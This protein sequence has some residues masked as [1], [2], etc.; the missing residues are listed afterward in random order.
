MLGNTLGPII[1]AP[2]QC[3]PAD[4]S[5]TLC[6]LYSAE[7]TLR[8]SQTVAADL[9]AAQVLA[10]CA[11][12]VAAISPTSFTPWVKEVVPPPPQFVAD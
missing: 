10:L 4:Q 11:A 9:Y 7:E 6:R 2:E 3:F 8:V 1:L 12:L 5:A